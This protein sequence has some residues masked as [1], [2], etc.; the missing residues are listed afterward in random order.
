MSLFGIQS[1]LKTTTLMFPL[2]QALLFSCSDQLRAITQLSYLSQNHQR[3]SKTPSYS[4]YN[5]NV[6][7][8]VY[9]FDF[10]LLIEAK[11]WNISFE[12][13]A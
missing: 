11:H 7:V 5:I 1:Q 8:S 10:N 6:P 12:M 13:I 9:L 4:Y 3:P 2:L